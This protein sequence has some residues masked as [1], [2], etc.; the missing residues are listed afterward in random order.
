[1]QELA[2][3]RHAVREAIEGL[4]LTPVMFELGARPYPPRALYRAYLEQ[5]DVFVGLYWESYGWV[6]PG[7]EASG[8]EDEYLLSGDRPKLIYLKTPAPKRQPR[9]D[10]LIARIQ[11]DDVSYRPFGTADELR[12]LV[13]DD[14]AVL[15]TE[16]FAAAEA[17]VGPPRPAALRPLPRPVTRLIGR[18]GDVARVLDLLGDPEVR[19]VTIVGPGGIG[20][21]RLALAVA[22]G[23]RAR[24]PD[25]IVYI[26]LAPL[27]EPSL[28][29]QTM[30]KSLGIE[31]QA[32]TNVGAQLRDRLAKARM[33]IVLDNMEQL[34]EAAT[35]CPT[36]WQRQRPSWCSSPVAAYSTSAA[37]ASMPL[38]LWPYRPTVQSRRQWSSSLSGLGASTPDTSRLTRTSRHSASCRGGLTGCRWQ[39]SWPRPGCGSCPP[40]LS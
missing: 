38:S 10:E 37:S 32:G 25:G 22:E 21:S 30:A 28:V 18:E 26:D 2:P 36:C 11:G 5:S 15:L 9:L 29:L 16:R 6:A 34:A 4:H 7:E 23:A 35:K 33:L 24:C 3:E 31:E 39:L 19:M 1:M 17:P 14:L 12:T 13:A 27:A 8:L 40:A 20:K